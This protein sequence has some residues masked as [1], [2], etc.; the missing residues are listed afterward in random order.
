MKEAPERAQL[1]WDDGN[2]KYKD[3][4]NHH[5]ETDDTLKLFMGS[6]QGFQVLKYIRV[7]N[8]AFVEEDSVDAAS[9]RKVHRLVDL[10]PASV[11]M[12]VLARPRSSWNDSIQLL[13]GLPELK[14]ERVPKLEMVD[15]ESDWHSRR[16]PNKDMKMKFLANGID[17]IL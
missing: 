3:A 4:K 2:W 1:C 14:A 11:E 12:V 5:H 15:F 17:L 13:E 16:T 6:L 10:L 9:G 8:E 7:Q